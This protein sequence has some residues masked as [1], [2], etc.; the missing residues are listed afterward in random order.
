VRI[1]LSVEQ[2]CTQYA[3]EDLHHGKRFAA[4]G[5][6]V[7]VSEHSNSA[8]KNTKLQLEYVKEID[9]LVN[10]AVDG[11]TVLKYFFKTSVAEFWTGFSNL[12]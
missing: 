3:K 8:V 4:S 9:H 7:S 11:R 2:D 5:Q 6:C 1:Q 10:L 12:G